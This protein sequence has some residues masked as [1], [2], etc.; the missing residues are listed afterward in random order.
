MTVAGLGKFL[1]EMALEI[2]FKEWKHLEGERNN[3]GRVGGEKY[4][5]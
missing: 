4:T 5:R 1:W 3:E 2:G